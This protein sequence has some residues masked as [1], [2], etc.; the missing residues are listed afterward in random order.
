MADVKDAKSDSH[1][2]LAMPELE[3]IEDERV[4]PRFIESLDPLRVAP[5]QTLR[6]FRFTGD[7]DVLRC[8][9]LRELHMDDFK[10]DAVGPSIH[11]SLELTG[12]AQTAIRRANRRLVLTAGGSADDAKDAAS[13]AK[14]DAKDD[15]KDAASDAKD[16]ASN[17]LCPQC[18]APARPGV[19]IHKCNAC[20]IYICCGAAM[21][22][23]AGAMSTFVCEKCPQSLQVD[24]LCNYRR[25]HP[26]S[27]RYYTD[28]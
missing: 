26:S 28:R 16:A 8:V 2:D 12:P 23:H 1:D 20:K 21:T 19:S 5:L 7:L 9:P 17:P 11:Q 10:G 14:D 22:A 15:A 24:L 4:E 27:T 13:N 18:H 3:D 6:M 25:F